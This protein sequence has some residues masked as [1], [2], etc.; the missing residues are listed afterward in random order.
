MPLRG[1]GFIQGYN[2]KVARG[3]DGLSLVGLVTSQTTDYA[4]FIP[5]LAQIAAASD[6]L[7][8]YARRPLNRK[9]AR[10]VQADAS[11]LSQPNL[12]CREANPTWEL[13]LQDGDDSRNY[14]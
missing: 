7:R 5:L 13:V 8:R 10:T 6:L 1:S 12:T 9:K 2:A 14:G 3:A 4:C 11:Y